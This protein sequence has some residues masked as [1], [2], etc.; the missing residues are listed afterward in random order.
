M[1]NLFV[2]ETQGVTVVSYKTDEFPAFFTAHSGYKVSQLCD[3]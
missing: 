3:D 2:Q 1:F